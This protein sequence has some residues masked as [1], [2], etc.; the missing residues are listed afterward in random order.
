MIARGGTLVTINESGTDVEQAT[1]LYTEFGST[2][3]LQVI[4]SRICSY[5]C[6]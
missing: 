6:E 5:V 2:C 3:K 1:Q 4:S